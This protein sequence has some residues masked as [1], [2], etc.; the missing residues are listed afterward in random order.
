MSRAAMA[1][2]VALCVS[3]VPA[4][5]SE[6]PS[7]PPLVSTAW[8]AEHLQDPDLVLV[9]VAMVH[10]GAP[11]RLVPG[12][13][14]LD[15]H[16]I[17]TS[18]G[19]SVEMPPVDRLVTTFRAVGVSNA[20]R[21]VL[22]GPS[23]AHLA[24]R[25]FVTLEYLGHE[26]VSVMDGGIEAWAEEGRVVV[27]QPTPVP[28]GTF[29]AR[30]NPDVLVDADWIKA[31]LGDPKL[32][33]VD[34]RPRDQF[35]GQVGRLRPGHIPGARNLY[36]VDLLQSAEVHRLKP[37]PEARALFEAAGAGADKVVVNYCQIGMRASYDYLV[38]RQ[39]GYTTRFYDGSWS[40]WAAR[41]DLPA[42]TG[43]R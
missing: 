41:E 35:E 31:H 37:E 13:V 43:A 33:L 29:E 22:Y 30:L 6:K 18:E 1:A 40:E 32:A 16:A 14:F 5:A 7:V 25:A 10:Q 39:L 21:V 42:E 24:A 9:H 20:S 27:D 3:S 23:P 4:A 15:Y 26:R 12:A 19:L 8:V 34:A 11:D 38:A 28:P 17:E 36:F 2:V